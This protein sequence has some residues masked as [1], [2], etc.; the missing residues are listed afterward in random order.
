M[1]PDDLRCL[2][3]EFQRVVAATKK[4]RVPVWVLTLV[5]NNK[6]KP[7]ELRTLGLGARE[8]NDRQ[9]SRV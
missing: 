5:T 2:G 6:W 7:D 8:N 4:T 1:P 3:S 9:W